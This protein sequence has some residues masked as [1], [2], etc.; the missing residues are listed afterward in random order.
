MGIL[1]KI[2]EVLEEVKEKVE[3]AMDCI[4]CDEDRISFR[5]RIFGD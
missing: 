2:R 5:R 3:D 1:D 4:R